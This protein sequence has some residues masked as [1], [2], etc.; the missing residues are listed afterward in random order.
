MVVFLLVVLVG[1][2]ILLGLGW[3]VFSLA[4]SPKKVSLAGKHVVITGGSSGIGKE[5][6]KIVARQG[7][8]V[9]IVARNVAKLKVATAEIKAA[10]SSNLGVGS[11]ESSELS[12]A[13][14]ICQIE[15]ISADLSKG[16]SA[17]AEAFK[18]V[19]KKTGQ[20]PIDVLVCSAGHSMPRRF[21]ESKAEEME[22]QVQL[23]YL[24]MLHSVHAVLPGMVE[25]CGQ[26][27]KNKSGP[28]IVLVASQLAQLGMYGFT[29]YSPTKFA[30]RGFAESLQMEVHQY[31]IHISLA[32]PPDTDTPGYQ[33]EMKIK[34][35]ET[36]LMS[37]SGA[38]FSA[39]KVA[40][41][42]VAGMKLGK[43]FISSGFD[44][45]LLCQACAGMAPVF[46][47]WDAISQVALSSLLRFV[48]LFY[49]TSWYHVAAKEHKHQ[50]YEKK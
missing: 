17:V 31:G 26:G 12:G 48:S 45:W 4:V 33:E 18:A 8:H 22:G 25:R 35:Q 23:N 47:F 43:F 49:L 29:G 6:A 40:G 10:A 21:L 3:I 1:V 28:R 44:G 30:V 14:D 24:G 13:Q 39:N 41:D 5:I 7:A 11:N 27:A 9:T 46:H 50:K 42:I 32:F 20:R 37:E 16:Y 36:K 2:L 34:P 19:D 38:L 15:S